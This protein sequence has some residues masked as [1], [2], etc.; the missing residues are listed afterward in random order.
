[1]STVLAIETSGRPGSVAVL[2]TGSPP[3]E[4]PLPGAGRGHAR[5]LVP[6]INALLSE[7]GLRMADVDAVAV[8]VGPGSFTG[9]RIGV[10][11]AKT[12]AWS[13]RCPAVP[14]DTFD[15]IADRVP[16][17]HSRF[18]VLDD[19][20]RGDVFV[21]PYSRDDAGIPVAE[22]LIEILP[23]D[24]WF[25]RVTPNDVV[26]GP[27]ATRFEETLA[28]RCRLIEESLRGATAGSVARLAAA[29]LE[30]GETVD[31]FE[32][33]PQYHRRSSAEVQ[34][35]RRRESGTPGI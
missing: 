22:A 17:E 7:A 15:A 23:R 5:F 31:P 13:L 16:T 25:A 18:L 34:W 4:R 33:V 9:L 28:G 32:L 3:I 26:T 12:I 8:S 35:D 2:S 21:R 27:G 14:V 10:V 6:E 20:Q 24:E 30:R 19:A 29:N 1:M 11:A